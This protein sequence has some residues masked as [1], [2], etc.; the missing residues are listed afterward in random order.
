ML[1]S[2]PMRSMYMYVSSLNHPNEHIPHSY[3]Y[4]GRYDMFHW[5]G[6]LL[7][8]SAAFLHGLLQLPVFLS[9]SQQLLLQPL[10]TTVGTYEVLH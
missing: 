9:H 2:H 4:L 7:C 10:I 8:C 5:E 1:N 3:S 6:S